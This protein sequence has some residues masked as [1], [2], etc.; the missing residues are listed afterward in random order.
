MNIKEALDVLK[1]IQEEYEKMNV[2]MVTKAYTRIRVKAPQDMQSRINEAYTILLNYKKSKTDITPLVSNDYHDIGIKLN[3]K[4]IVNRKTNNYK[5]SIP[6]KKGID[7]LV[8]PLQTLFNNVNEGE[9]IITPPYLRSKMTI[10]GFTKD[11][12][13]PYEITLI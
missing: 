10:F 3:I 7:Q 13:I 8:T 5:A 4:P 11:T 2:V 12:N 9:F 1:I 6:Y